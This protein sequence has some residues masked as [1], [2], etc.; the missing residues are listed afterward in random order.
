MN[1]KRKEPFGRPTKYKQEYCEMLIEHMS[2]G[3]SFESFAGFLGV[4]RASIYEWE[5]KN[6]DFS[7]A[8]AIAFEKSRYFWES[9]SV[10]HLIEKPH[11][12]KLNNT[13][14]VFNMKNRFG[15]TDKTE[16]ES[17]NTEVKLSYNVNSDDK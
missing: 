3:Y 17:N 2:R 1:K 8:K 12:K 13:N 6:K 7:D 15:W 5:Q 9:A 4:A 14:W 10:E 16:I 11:G